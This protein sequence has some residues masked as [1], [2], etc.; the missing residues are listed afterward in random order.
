MPTL[1]GV[2]GICSDQ[3]YLGWLP[4]KEY[5]ITPLYLLP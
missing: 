1:F 4:M 5:A 3:L 2:G